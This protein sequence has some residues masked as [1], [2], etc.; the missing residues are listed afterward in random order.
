MLSVSVSEQVK[1]KSK[2]CGTVTVLPVTVEFGKFVGSDSQYNPRHKRNINGS[3]CGSNRIH[4][5]NSD[6]THVS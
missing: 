2:K 1:F 5:Q 6:N 3:N 4:R